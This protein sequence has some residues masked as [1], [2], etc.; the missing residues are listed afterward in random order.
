MACEFDFTPVSDADIDHQA[1][2]GPV[3]CFEAAVARELR[4]SRAA[5]RALVDANDDHTPAGRLRWE[6][7]AADIRALVAHVGEGE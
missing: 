2:T 3:M 4:A 6:K 5:M 1:G 7:A